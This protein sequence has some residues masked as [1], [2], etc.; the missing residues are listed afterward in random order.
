MTFMHCLFVFFAFMNPSCQ[1]LRML[2]CSAY[3]LITWVTV[4]VHAL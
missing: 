1:V 2:F 4:A 3:V